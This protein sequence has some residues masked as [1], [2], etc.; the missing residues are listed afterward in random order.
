MFKLLSTRPHTSGTGI[1]HSETI[2]YVCLEQKIVL[3]DYKFDFSTIS[4]S[5]RFNVWMIPIYVMYKFA[6]L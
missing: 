2:R 4:A 6:K 5:W 3:V 1:H